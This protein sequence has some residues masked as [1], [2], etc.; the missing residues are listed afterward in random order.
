MA[1]WRSCRSDRFSLE[2]AKSLFSLI[3]QKCCILSASRG[4]CGRAGLVLDSV[5]PSGVDFINP[6]TPW[7]K[8]RA[9]R[10]GDC[11][12][13]SKIGGA[14]GHGCLVRDGHRRCVPGVRP[15]CR[16]SLLTC[17]RRV[18][19]AGHSFAVQAVTGGGEGGR[20]PEILPSYVPDGCPRVR[21]ADEAFR[22][23][24]PGEDSSFCDSV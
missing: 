7:L 8:G 12:A 18:C 22:S 24:G 2:S 5:R 19:C 1:K 6:P 3:D 13:A 16:A 14:A 9:H 10:H 23:S 15:T 20:T 4:G 21:A 17:S 11:L